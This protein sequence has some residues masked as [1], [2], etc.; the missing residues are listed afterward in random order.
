MLA[1]AVALNVPVVAPEGTVT[2]T[3]TDRRALLL[4]SVT[5]A[6]PVRAVWSRVTVQVL[7]SLWLR[8]AGTHASVDTSTGVWRAIVALFELD[9]RVAVAV[10]F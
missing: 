6:P 4:P 1:P 3:G 9:P 5:L 8:V 7:T 10:A 2:E